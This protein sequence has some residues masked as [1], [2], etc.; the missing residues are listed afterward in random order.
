M[1][2]DLDFAEAELQARGVHLDCFSSKNPLLIRPSQKLGRVLAAQSIINEMIEMNKEPTP[3]EIVALSSPDQRDGNTDRDGTELTRVNDKQGMSAPEHMD[4]CTRSDVLLKV[5]RDEHS[6]GKVDDASGS[7]DSQDDDGY[8][9]DQMSSVGNNDD[10]GN[11]SAG[12]LIR[13]PETEVELVSMLD[14]SLSNLPHFRSRVY[15]EAADRTINS[16][17][18][19]T[20]SQS[21]YNDNNFD[22]EDNTGE[23][24]NEFG[25]RDGG[26]DGAKVYAVA[27]ADLQDDGE[28]ND[29]K[30]TPEE[31]SLRSN[32]YEEPQSKQSAEPTTILHS[33]E[34]DLISPICCPPSSEITAPGDSVHTNSEGKFHPQDPTTFL[35]DEFSEPQQGTS[36]ETLISTP[37]QAEIEKPDMYSADVESYSGMLADDSDAELSLSGTCDPL[38]NPPAP[39]VLLDE[40]EKWAPESEAREA[41]ASLPESFVWQDAEALE[42]SMRDH[43]SLVPSLQSSLTWVLVHCQLIPPSSPLVGFLNSSAAE[44]L[45]VRLLLWNEC[46]HVLS[47]V[48]RVLA[49]QVLKALEK[50]NPLVSEIDMGDVIE[51]AEAVFRSH[52][53]SVWRYIGVVTSLLCLPELTGAVNCSETSGVNSSAGKCGCPGLS[54]LVQVFYPYLVNQPR[55]KLRDQWG[56]MTHLL[57][58]HSLRLDKLAFLLDPVLKGLVLV[59][60]SLDVRAGGSSSRSIDDSDRDALL[61]PKLAIV[62]ERGDILRSSIDAV[63]TKHL[64][65]KDAPQHVMLY[66]FFRSP[67][68]EKVV[69]NVRVEEGEG[70]GPL[71]EWFALVGENLAAKWRQIEVDLSFARDSADGDIVANGNRLVVPHSV[72][73]LIRPGFQVEWEDSMNVGETVVRVVNK[74]DPVSRDTF[75][76]DR[77]VSSQSFPV[78]T[79]RLAEPC[80]PIFDYI[81]ASESYS[82]N[83]L[84]ADTAENRRTFTFVGWLLATT[85]THSCTIR[86]RLH[87]L[88]FSLL[89]NPDY[90]VTLRDLK[91]FDPVLL[92]SLEQIKTMPKT[93][94]AALLELEEVDP[95]FTAEE[96]ISHTLES[97]FGSS[98][99]LAWQ[100]DAIRQGFERVISVGVATRLGLSGRDM[101]ALVCGDSCST[102]ISDSTDFQIDLVF[103]VAADPDF[104]ACAPLSR[105]FWRTVNKFDPSLKRKLVKFITGVD[106]LP[107]PGTEVRS[108]SRFQCFARI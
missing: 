102:G 61:I 74:E 9:E 81:R 42:S 62:C 11:L 7:V 84:T 80:T 66:P 50:E 19:D 95:S 14:E 3:Q 15:D 72:S 64:S 67:Y 65:S 48:C 37:V 79:L 44:S 49:S 38:S 2:S 60:S 30:S 26:P 57:T 36:S 18:T 76:L 71:K 101:A 70:K 83:A 69:D 100:L 105:G 1:N 85:I 52:D 21:E 55:D 51:M 90:R 25:A 63:W 17:R 73:H 86:L 4:S 43:A 6:G 108:S 27:T 31:A 88:I 13:D 97:T 10:N 8:G 45:A 77:A 98:S 107:V 24:A 59:V 96:Y 58:R 91:E 12:V 94:L 53:D 20:S 68:G 87:H 28:E 46:N 32:A 33:E 40:L 34:P 22:D 35:A 82:L 99:S 39:Q 93:D 41:I 29:D 56:V 16:A 23:Y 89:L 5:D 75:L 103:R 78:S 92:K 54:E 106:T 47:I 104:A